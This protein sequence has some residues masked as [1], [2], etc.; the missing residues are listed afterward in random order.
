MRACTS[1]S[2]VGRHRQSSSS[3]LTCQVVEIL[4]GKAV[5]KLINIQSQFVSLLPNIQLPVTL[6]HHYSVATFV[7]A[8]QRPCCHF[9]HS[10]YVTL[11]PLVTAAQPPCHSCHFLPV[12]LA[13]FAT[14][15]LPLLTLA[16]LF[17][18]LL[19]LLSQRRSRPVATFATAAKL[20]CPC[21]IAA[22]FPHFFLGRDEI[23]KYSRLNDWE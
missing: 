5:R 23:W 12:T 3:Q 7:T 1:F 14:A 9:C 13:T 19:P 21:R 4:L 8:A 2:K 10:L 11:A 16:T 15:A 20:P 18:P 22:H 17:P 6:D